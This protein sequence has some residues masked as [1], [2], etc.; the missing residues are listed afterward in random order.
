MLPLL[1]VR[2][3]GTLPLLAMEAEPAG[4]L[5]LLVV[6]ME[7]EPAGMLPLLVVVMEAEPAGMLAYDLLA[8]SKCTDGPDSDSSLAVDYH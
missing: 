6:A 4:M 1:V 5:P 2:P 8:C 3:A 7:A